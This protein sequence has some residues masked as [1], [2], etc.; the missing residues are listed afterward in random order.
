MLGSPGFA[1]KAA[2]AAVIVRVIAVGP[3]R[4]E[5]EVVMTVM[6]TVEV[7]R[8]RRQWWCGRGWWAG[9][10]LLLPL[11]PATRQLEKTVSTVTSRKGYCSYLTLK[12]HDPYRS[13]C[14]G[15]QQ[16]AIRIILPLD[17]SLFRSILLSKYDVMP[18][19]FG[20]KIDQTRTKNIL[21]V[22]QCVV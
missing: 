17:L 22:Y 1:A 9:L 16:K 4:F 11:L 19:L 7:F 20:L 14:Q 8:R 13:Y 21:Q 10:G 15:T 6:M 5:E 12:H 3:Q 18:P 2:C